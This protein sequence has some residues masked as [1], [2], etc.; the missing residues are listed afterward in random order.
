MPRVIW[1][2][3]ISFGLVHVPVGL[4]PAEQRDELHLA[5]LDRRDLSPVGYK[6]YNKNTGE[7]TPWEEI[8][9][10]YEYEKGQ[11]V[12]LGDEDLRRANAEATQT[13]EIV[14]FV[15]ADEIP[16]MYLDKPYYLE[17]LQRGEKGYALLRETLRR[18]G[19][20]GIAKVVLRTRQY[21]SA[22]LPYGDVLVLELL[23]YQD[24]LRKPAELKVPGPDLDALGIGARE[25]EMAERL[26]EGMAAEWQPEK[27]RDEYREDLLRLIEAKV[28]SGELAEVAQPTP[29]GPARAEVID[30]MSLLKR[31]VEETQKARGKA[32]ARPPKRAAAKGTPKGT[33][34]G[35]KK[36]A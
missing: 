19:K 28:Q 26:V 20:A 14:D 6:R 36:R 10:G 2:G 9:K 5:M 15:P 32:P 33:A 27:Y 8:V 11:Y 17:P 12:V 7:E 35:G 30:L 1:K 13:V 3:S 16:V 34:K 31:S 18:T 25:V 4:Y 22:L 23:R 21:L 29:E 24:E